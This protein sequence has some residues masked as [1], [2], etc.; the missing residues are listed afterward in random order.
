[1]LV[2]VYDFFSVWLARKLN[3]KIKNYGKRKEKKRKEKKEKSI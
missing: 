2:L 1:V 3:W